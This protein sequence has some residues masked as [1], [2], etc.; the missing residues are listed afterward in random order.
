MK[1]GAFRGRSMG[2]LRADKLQGEQK[3]WRGLWHETPGTCTAGNTFTHCLPSLRFRATEEGGCVE[4]LN[5]HCNGSKFWEEDKATSV[6]HQTLSGASRRHVA[7]LQLEEG[8]FRSQ[9][10]SYPPEREAP[11]PYSHHAST[12]S[13]CLTWIVFWKLC[14]FQETCSFW[15][16]VALEVTC[17]IV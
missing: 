2:P 12:G 10:K 14:Y 13:C 5:V 3:S 6:P 11:P 9:R 8:F 4:P 1:P 16:R 7:H 15:K 17:L